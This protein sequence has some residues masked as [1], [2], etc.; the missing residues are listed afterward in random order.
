MSLE[1]LGAC[2]LAGC[3]LFAREDIDSAAIGQQCAQRGIQNAC[4][5]VQ[6]HYQILSDNMRQTVQFE[7][8]LCAFSGQ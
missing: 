5:L 6:S 1:V 4:P 7:F 3:E 2:S 8:W